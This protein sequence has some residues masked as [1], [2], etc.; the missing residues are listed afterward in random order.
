MPL[1]ELVSEIGKW[2]AGTAITTLQPT[3]Y[4][5]ATTTGNTDWVVSTATLYTD[6]PGLNLGSETFYTDWGSSQFSQ[7]L[8]ANAGTEH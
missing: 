2:R 5:K 7:S 6:V 8:H 4:I 1:L 3:I